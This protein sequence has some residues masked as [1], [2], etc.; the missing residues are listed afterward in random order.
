MVAENGRLRSDLA[1]RALE[2]YDLPRCN[3][4]FIGHSDTLT[5]RV[6]TPELE[7]FL[8]RIH[9]PVT[10]AMGSQGA[11]P[12]A[13][14]SELLWLEALRRDTDLVLQRPIRNQSGELAS[15]VLAEEPV[16]WVNCSLL[17]WVDGQPYLRHLESEETAAQIG[18]ILAKLH[19]HSSQWK[20]PAGFTRPRRDMAYFQGV[21]RGLQPAVDD[22]RI[23]PSDHAELVTSVALLCDM[24][25]ATATDRPTHSIMHADA[26]KGNLLYQAGEIRLIDF[27][28]CSLGDLA[29]DLAVCL[30]D[31]NEGLHRAFVASYRR[32]RALPDGDQRLIEG[33]FV[34]SL[35]GAFSYWVPNPRAQSLL[36]THVPRIVRAYATQFNRG[37]RFL[38][39]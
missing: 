18:T 16:T 17:S 30:S 3:L 14:N 19:L 10:A 1:R 24:M 20:P 9:L 11:D 37:A 15:Q 28:F 22:G 21:L 29:V 35:V 25:V 6:E 5:F 8:L 27:S 39:W 23:S 34:G 4:K 33:F 38:S 31:M 32:L 13:I 2:A 7:A 36:A 12:A 26:H